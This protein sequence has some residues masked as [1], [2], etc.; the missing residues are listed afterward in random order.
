MVLVTFD[1][2]PHET[3]SPVHPFPAF[4]LSGCNGEDHP[5]IRPR[6][7]ELPDHD[8]ID[9]PLIAAEAILTDA[10]V[11]D[12][13]PDRETEATGPVTGGR[14]SYRGGTPRKARR[15]VSCTPDSD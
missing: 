13:P 3:S 9:K 7:Y 5:D 2:R 10:E 12:L 1:S 14:F 11:E 8:I 15:K 4:C 6:G